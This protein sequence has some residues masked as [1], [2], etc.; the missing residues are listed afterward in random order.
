M[1]TLGMEL[2]QN[3]A[4]KQITIPPVSGKKPSSAD[5]CCKVARVTQAY[6]LSGIDDE[7]RRRYRDENATLHELA[8]YFNDR[9]T[10]VAVDVIENPPETEPGT[11]RAA[12]EGKDSIPATKRDDIRADL[13]GQLDIDMLTNNYVSHET[14]RKHLNDHLDISTSK[15]GF[16]TFD[17]LKEQLESYQEQ[18]ENGVRSALKRGSKKGLIEGGDFRIFSTRVECENCS[19]TY[20]LQEL[21]QKRGCSCR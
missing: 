20:R 8:D 4:E 7:L 15:G 1:Q 13:A 12:L 10:A 18:Y 14:I 21:V 9:I 16:E 11:V 3:S 5:A 2:N 19:E 6:Q 17:E